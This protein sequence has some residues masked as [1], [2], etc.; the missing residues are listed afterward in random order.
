MIKPFVFISTICVAAILV[1][2]GKDSEE[3]AP[4]EQL[5]KAEAEAPEQP[6]SAPPTESSPI[7]ETASTLE[8]DHSNDPWAGYH[9]L[10]SVYFAELSAIAKDDPAGDAVMAHAEKWTE[11]HKARVFDLCK[12]QQVMLAKAP[13]KSGPL[14][15]KYILWEAGLEGDV[16]KIA[17]KFGSKKAPKVKAA[18]LAFVSTALEGRAAGTE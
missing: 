13:R 6:E 11:T 14:M 1:G 7:T 9:D 3:P 10:V 5:E 2:C 4:S 18:V 15:S 8:V 16:D 17:E 12:Q